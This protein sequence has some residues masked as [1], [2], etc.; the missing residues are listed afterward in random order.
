MRN[1]A[2]SSHQARARIAERRSPRLLVAGVANVI[3][4]TWPL[5][6]QLAEKGS[7]M[8]AL[9]DLVPRWRIGLIALGHRPRGVRRYVDQVKEFVRFLGPGA[10]LGQVTT[11]NITSY[12]ERKAER[13]APETL[14][15]A[16]SA[17]RSFCRWCV[18]TD[19]RDDDPTLSI[20]WP[21]RRKPAPRALKQ[22]ELRALLA[23]LEEPPGLNRRAQFICRR[24]R[25]AIYLM[26][27][28]GLR[29]SEAAALRWRD[30]DLD[31]AVLMVR[32]GK[33][34]KDRVVPLHAKLLAELRVAASESRPLRAVAGNANGA[35]LTSKSMAHLFERWL[36][37]LG[38]R[39]TAHQL[40][41]SFASEL[42]RGGASLRD[43]QELLGHASLATTQRYL[44]ISAEQLREAVDKLPDEW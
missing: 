7:H 20:H 35:P 23:A 3:A 32:E 29:I 38:L 42:L 43:I 16:L 11:R 37:K 1:T 10:T 19:L 24:N 2:V 26:L 12:Q 27:F 39:I 14:G 21:K 22:R 41:H 6:V 40:R 8:D 31:A 36:P 13:C 4:V 34:G 30:V 44:M 9:E 28:A 18:T 5:C 33:G 15:N 17:I 25:R